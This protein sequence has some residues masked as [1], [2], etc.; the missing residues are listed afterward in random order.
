VFTGHNDKN[1]LAYLLTVPVAVGV[2]VIAGSALL[3]A[4]LVSRRCRC[5]AVL[6]LPAVSTDRGRVGLAL[7]TVA[8]LLS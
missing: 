3:L 5:T 7:L 4:L 8:A 1:S 6:V 2:A